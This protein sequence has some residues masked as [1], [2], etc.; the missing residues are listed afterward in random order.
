[1]K[2]RPVGA[3]FFSMR[4]DGQADMAKLIVAV[5]DFAKSPKNDGKAAET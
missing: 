3:N 2:I 1:M 4:N 5:R